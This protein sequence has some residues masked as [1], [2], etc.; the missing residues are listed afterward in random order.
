MIDF[1]LFLGELKQPS[2]SI[3][4]GSIFAILF[5]F[6]IYITETLLMAST[7]DRSVIIIYFLYNLILFI[8]RYTLLNNYLFLLDINIWQPFVIIGIIFAVF[9]SCLS[10][11]IGA[12]RIL[13]ALSKDEIFGID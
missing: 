13:A 9:S 3:P 7:T 1:I 11:L 6:F 5:V 12:S 8:F 2:R 10:G 4:L